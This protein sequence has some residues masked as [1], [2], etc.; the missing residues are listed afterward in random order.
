MRRTQYTMPASQTGGSVRHRANFP[1]FLHSDV[2]PSRLHASL[3]SG[4]TVIPDSN[5]CVGRSLHRTEV[6]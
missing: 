3:P 6:T 1:C 4:T 5:E 2:L